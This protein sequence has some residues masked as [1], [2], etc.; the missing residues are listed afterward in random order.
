MEN[1]VEK[2]GKIDKN[3]FTFAARQMRFENDRPTRAQ[4]N[5]EASISKKSNTSQS[6]LVQNISFAFFFIKG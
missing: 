5:D 1:I 3:S 4:Q 6:V 2:M